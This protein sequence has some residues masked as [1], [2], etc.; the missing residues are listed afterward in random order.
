[1]CQMVKRVFRQIAFFCSRFTRYEKKILFRV[2]VRLQPARLKKQTNKH[3][4]FI[5]QMEEIELYLIVPGSMVFILRDQ[6]HFPA[7]ALQ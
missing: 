6:K 7:I 4:R 2:D 1:M 5:S 3:G